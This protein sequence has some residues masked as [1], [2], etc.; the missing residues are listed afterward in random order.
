MGFLFSSKTGPLGLPLDPLTGALIGKKKKSG[1]DDATVKTDVIAADAQRP[2]PEDQ[3]GS[4]NI[5]T[6][7]DDNAR[8]V[9]PGLRRTSSL[10]SG[11]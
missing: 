3:L 11:K 2:D 1:G 7:L 9:R 4:S 8:I 5:R 6:P 10:L